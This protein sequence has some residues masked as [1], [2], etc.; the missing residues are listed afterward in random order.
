MPE[1]TIT[2][3][4][5]SKT[6]ISRGKVRVQAL[7]SVTFDAPAHGITCIV[8]PTGSGK[9][10]LLRIVS[11]IEK[12]DKGEVLLEGLPPQNHIGNIGYLTQHHNL[13]PWLKVQDNI[14]LPLDLKGVS[15]E[16]RNRTV[17]EITS[18]LG[19]EDAKGLYPY[20]L[21]GGMKQR[22]TIGRLLASEAKYWL[23]D[24]PFSSLDERTRHRL[25]NLLLKLIREYKITTL[26]VTH[27][28]D[29]AVYLA[30]R[31]IILSCGPGRV[32]DI[33]EPEMPHPR[34]RLSNEYGDLMER[35]RRR[36]ES[37]LTE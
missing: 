20:E 24:E 8:G 10:T 33:I 18:L 19:L 2:V 34:N 7:E 6:F 5:L 4:N 16:R 31:I 26:F 12:P 13:F 3:R 21:S 35:V 36:I 29:E 23:L 1:Q 37:I 9:T 15:I 11:G 25:Q 32:V 30:D 28:I 22:V 17:D 27:S 14:A